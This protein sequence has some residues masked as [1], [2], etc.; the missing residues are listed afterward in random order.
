MKPGAYTQTLYQGELGVAT[1]SVTVTAGSTATGQHITSGWLTPTAIFRIGDWDGAPTSFKN[2]SNLT[3]MHPSDTRMASWGPT[4]YT[5]G[6]SSVGAFPAY[7][8]TGVNDPTT[9]EFT[10]SAGQVAART[11]RIGIS[12]AYAGG[13]PRISVNSWTSAIPSPSTQP[14]SRSL[15]IGTYRGDNALFTYQVPASAFVTG[16]NTMRIDI[17]SGSS[18]AGYLSPG[19]AFDCVELF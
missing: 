4:T 14:T 2:G 1:R 5:V 13:R 17:V 7:Q 15:T 10:L 16:T 6:S 3:V 9:V 12:A 8:W 18:G 19:V 11:V